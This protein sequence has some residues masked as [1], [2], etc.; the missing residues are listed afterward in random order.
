MLG[1][2]EVSTLSCLEDL[3]SLIADLQ[4]YIIKQDNFMYFI[5]QI[6]SDKIIN[7]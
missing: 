1:I 2:W 6:Y 7:Y 5:K 3:I 4:Y